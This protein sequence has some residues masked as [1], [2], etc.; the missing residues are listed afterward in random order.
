MP[1]TIAAQLAKKVPIPG[2]D[3]ASRQASITV[4][5]EVGDLAQVPAHAAQLYRLAEQAVDTQLG[6]STTTS[7]PAGTIASSQPVP[8]SYAPRSTAG[9]APPNRSRRPAPVTDSQL[10]LIDRLLRD[11]N[12]DP[13]AI[14]RHHQVQ[15]M[16]DLSCKVASQVID[17]LKQLTEQR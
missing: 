15:A 13:A 3:F 2:T 11:T 5:A 9:S 8:R 6:L 16:A 4:T 12:T 17:D 10:R 14:L 7:A 1:I